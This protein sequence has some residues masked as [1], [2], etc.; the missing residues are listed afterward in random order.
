M[1]VFCHFWSAAHVVFFLNC[2]W[3]WP[4]YRFPAKLPVVL[5]PRP[6]K[7]IL[8]FCIKMAKSSETSSGPALG[9][10]HTLGVFSAGLS[11]FLSLACLH[12]LWIRHTWV[13][14]SPSPSINSVSS[15][16]INL[17]KPLFLICKIGMIVLPNSR[18]IVRIQRQVVKGVA[19]CLEW[20]MIQFPK[21]SCCHLCAGDCAS[22]PS[23]EL[24]LANPA[25]SGFGQERK[26]GR[27]GEVSLRK[28]FFPLQVFVSGSTWTLKDWWGLVLG[29]AS[30]IQWS[31]P[32]TPD[33]RL[34]PCRGICLPGLASCGLLCVFIPYSL[35][36]FWLWPTCVPGILLMM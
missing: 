15:G 30:R 26:G 21:G 25:L 24:G 9:S 27:I 34:S 12:W 2:Q 10:Q 18:V 11:S 28:T 1:K 14:T 7:S 17:P 20:V 22:A 23:Q 4:D 5:V 13:G 31:G 8:T 16:K 32:G 35:W 6:P 19:W 36:A 29:H 3:P 33:P